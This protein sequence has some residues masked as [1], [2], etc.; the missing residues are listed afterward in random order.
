MKAKKQ[1]RKL[2]NKYEYELD[3][4]WSEVKCERKEDAFEITM[5]SECAFL[6]CYSYDG[7]VTITS[8]NALRLAKTIMK[9]YESRK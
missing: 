1:I 3:D 8:K 7:N 5:D 4:Y 6:S 9:Y 2:P